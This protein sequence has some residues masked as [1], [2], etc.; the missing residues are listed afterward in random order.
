MISPDK[1][2][3][4]IRNY[5]FLF[6]CVITFLLAFYNIDLLERVAVIVEKLASSI[7]ILT[8]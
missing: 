3:K 4:L 2:Y 8:P 6:I 5:I 7:V 1:R